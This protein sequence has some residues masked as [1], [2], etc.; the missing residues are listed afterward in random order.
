MNKDRENDRKIDKQ[1]NLPLDYKKR[2]Y[3]AKSASSPPRGDRQR[4]KQIDMKKGS[5]KVRDISNK[6]T[7]RQTHLWTIGDIFVRQDLL[8]SHRLP[9]QRDVDIRQRR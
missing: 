6:Q 7:N 8:R 4:D 1:T 3:L 2:I 5:E 9:P